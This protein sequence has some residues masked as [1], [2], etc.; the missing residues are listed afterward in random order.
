MRDGYRNVIEADDNQRFI[1]IDANQS[2]E[3]VFEAAWQA[4]KIKL[5]DLQN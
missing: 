4:L 2:P 3:A 5:A 1:F